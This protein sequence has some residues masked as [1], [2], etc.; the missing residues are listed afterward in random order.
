VFSVSANVPNYPGSA[1]QIDVSGD[2]IIAE[3]AINGPD[4]PSGGG[5]V[6]THA[7]ILPNNSRLFVASAGSVVSG[8]VDGILSFTPSPQSTISTGFGGVTALSLPSQTSTITAISQSGNIVTATLSA[9]LN[10]VE[11]GYSIVIAGVVIPNCSESA[12][13]A[14]N[15]LAYDG[16]FNIYSINGTTLQVINTATGLPSLSGS[17]LTGA[18][19]SVPPQPVFLNTTQNNAIYVANYNSNSIFSVNASV[20]AVATTT[21]VGTHPVALAEIPNGMKLYVAN[22][23]SNTVS[24]LNTAGLSANVVT[25]F[26]G[27]SPVWVVARGDSQKVYVLTQGDGQLVTIDTNTDTV[28]SSLS[29]GAGANFVFFDPNLNRL[30]V[31]NP[32]TNA[33]YVFSD[34]GGANDT[35]TL[36]TLQPLTIPGLNAT[37]TP[38]CPTCG[39]PVPVSVTALLDGSRFYVAS[40][41]IASSCPD[42]AVGAVPCVIPG[43]SVFDA[44]SFALK[45]P[46]LTLLTDPPFAGPLNSS[47]PYQYA[48]PP[49]AA[50]GATV[51]PV[52]PIPAPLYAPGATR[53]RVFTTAAADSSA[54]YVSMCDAGAVAVI[55]ATDSNTNNTVGGGT[56]ADSLV[57]D[58]PAAYAGPSQIT[59]SPLQNPIFLLT[60]Q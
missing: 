11:A 58:L 15:P 56:P 49:V 9:A 53:F 10:N 34:T 1:M 14:C 51:P 7:A 38:A 26:S 21:P 27:V 41:Q 47:S 42:P 36:L 52:P 28:T 54:V 44:N 60:G 31:T 13:P 45:L 24:S 16:S 40:Y 20:N 8:G 6:P 33:I 19:A 30:Y 2:T 32:S 23:G 17:Q 48:V 3:T 55:N 59:G 43:L 18:A 39:A 37:T 57:T 46:T 50:C 22:Q 25:G 4:A 5:Q 29:V 35:P 12:Q